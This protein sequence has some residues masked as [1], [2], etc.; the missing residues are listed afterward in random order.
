MNVGFIGLG[1]MGAGIAMN[2]IRG[3]HSLVV[4]DVVREAAEDHLAAGAEWAGSAAEAASRSEVLLTSLPGPPEVEAVALG[5]GGIAEG[6]GK[7]LVWLDL[8]TSSPTLMRRLHAELGPRGVSVLDAPVSGGP[9]GARSGKL[10]IWAGGDEAAWERAL[11]VIRSVSDQPRHVGA[12]GAGSVVKLVHNLSGYMLQTALAECFTMG[13]KAGVP[14][15]ALWEAVRQG[16]VGRRR[17]Y[18]TMARQFLPGRFDP[19]D[20]ALRLA[21]KDV[22]LALE[23]GREFGV[24]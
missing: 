8:S 13:V 18:D 21:H 24:P 17:T 3:G 1:T 23:V 11:P 10:A 7:G 19:P 12:I 5:P 14:A 2:A 4:H 20:F 16:A 15:E 6:A 9:D 22:S